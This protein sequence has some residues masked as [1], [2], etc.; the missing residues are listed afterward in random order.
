MRGVPYTQQQQMR[1]AANVDVAGQL[2]RGIQTGAAIQSMVKGRRNQKQLN[3]ILNHPNMSMEE[4]AK[5]VSIIDPG[6][7]QQLLKLV[8][9]E[10]N[11]KR[12]QASHLSK[13]GLNAARRTD[14]QTGMQEGTEYHGARMNKSEAQ[15][16]EIQQRTDIQGAKHKWEEEDRKTMERVKARY[17]KAFD[18]CLSKGLDATKE[19]YNCAL[20]EL[21]IQG[22]AHTLKELYDFGEALKKD[23]E[24]TRNLKV[25][26]V[27]EAT[28]TLGTIIA[29][30]MQTTDQNRRA[31][32]IFQNLQPLIDEYENNPDVGAIVDLLKQHL[33]KVDGVSAPPS[34]FF[35]DIPSEDE[36]AKQPEMA[37]KHLENVKS[38]QMQQPQG[39]MK[40]D[41]SDEAL[42]MVLVKLGMMEDWSGST[43]EKIMGRF[44]GKEADE[45]QK[46]SR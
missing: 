36:L 38:G 7:A 13:M 4:K 12:V 28:K 11:E 43:L 5:A 24:K 26:E 19:D 42:A 29:G 6:I 14:I 9:M 30:A 2:M 37:R 15:T 10:A 21:G 39:E 18:S 40:L 8:H 34:E 44:G 32:F 45:E 22:A 33:T 23:D 46:R 1:P 41:V 20:K 35:K 27:N 31:Q 3:K 16:A 17:D 25:E